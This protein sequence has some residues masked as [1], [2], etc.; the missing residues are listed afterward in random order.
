MTTNEDAPFTTG[1]GK[2]EKYFNNIK[3]APLYEKTRPL[4]P[5]L[6]YK[7]LMD[8]LHYIPLAHH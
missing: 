5:N 6:K 2:T 8:L 3:L 4:T 7:N 1:T